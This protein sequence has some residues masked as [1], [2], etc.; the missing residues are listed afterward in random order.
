MEIGIIQAI[1]SIYSEGFIGASIDALMLFITFFG[2][3]LFLVLT[4]FVVYW[5]IDKKA[6]DFLVFSVY[7]S[8]G[9]NFTLKDV[10]SRQR[11]CF[12]E[13]CISGEIRHVKVDNFLLSTDYKA[14]SY[15]FPSGHASIGSGLYLGVAR[16][17]RRRWVTISTVVLSI[18]IAITRIYL[19]VHYP[20]D[21][22]VGLICGILCSIGFGTLYLK[23]IKYKH[24]IFGGV[25]LVFLISAII[26]GNT[27]T[28][29]LF[30][31]GAGYTIGTFFENKYVDFNSNSVWWKRIL[32]FLVGLGVT[33]V[34]FLP[35]FFLF[36]INGA[37]VALT[38]FPTIVSAVLLAP[39]LFKILKL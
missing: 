28:W 26:L 9:L 23:F 32:R 25:S 19:G 14:T 1:Q 35:C 13:A 6:G 12:S 8:A 27:S 37:C 4:L 18:L 17:V 36:G 30:G 2:E 7:L 21:V 5:C 31:V 24:A 29:A 38:L 3:S 34:V 10:F 16:Y 15:S 33:V 22:L 39:Y 11:P 20:S